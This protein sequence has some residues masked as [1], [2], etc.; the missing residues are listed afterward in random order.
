[1][2]FW[3]RDATL[4][5]GNKQY[6]LGGLN[7]TF[8]IPFEDSDEPP[9]ATVKVTNLSAATRAGIKKND[10]V[11]LN[12]GYEGDVGCILIGKVVGLKHKQANTDWTSTLTVQPCADEILGSLINKT[13]AKG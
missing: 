4:T 1:M 7:F 8:E 9:V 5:I 6:S 12:A 2:A 10:P 3:I 11:V 13:Y